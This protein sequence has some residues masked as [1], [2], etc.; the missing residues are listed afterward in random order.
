MVVAVGTVPIAMRSSAIHV[1]Q[2]AAWFGP[3][4]RVLYRWM[5]AR[6]PLGT[7]VPGA[8]T[9]DIALMLRGLAASDHGG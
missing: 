6:Q 2:V 7:Y 9:L 8:L 4:R 3:Y 5:R 1:S